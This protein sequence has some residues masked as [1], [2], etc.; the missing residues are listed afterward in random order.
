M[1]QLA[2][3]FFGGR[4]LLRLLRWR[5]VQRLGAWLLLLGFLPPV[6]GGCN[7]YRAKPQAADSPALSKLAETKFFLVHEG[8]QTWQL[9]SPHLEGETLVGTKA[10]VVDT[11]LPYLN[12]DPKATNRRFRN[13]DSRFVL[14]LV[15]LYLGPATLPAPNGPVRIPVRSIQRAEVIDEDTGRTLANHLGVATGITA[16]TLALLLVVVALTNICRCPTLHWL[17]AST[18]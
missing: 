8:S 14:N 17:T 13:H 2:S 9:T 11:Q 5:W 16:G 4:G 18:R 10:P 1:M 6:M 12:P 3:F 15:H 7:Y